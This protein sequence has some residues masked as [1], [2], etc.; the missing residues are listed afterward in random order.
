MKSQL[1]RFF[2]EPVTFTPYSTC[3]FSCNRLPRILDKTSGMYRRMVLIEL[4]NKITKPDPLFLLK[5]TQIDMEYFL[6]KAVYWIGVAMK[7]GHF[8]ISQ[9][10]KELLRKFKCRQSSLN[11]WLYE[12]HI[13]LGDI[14]QKISSGKLY[15]IHG[16]GTEKWL[17]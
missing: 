16:M 17:F 2:K 5:L 6:W 4:N 1:D 11:E 9:S 12:E 3:L 15:N 13:T 10:E 8:R 7:E 14:Y